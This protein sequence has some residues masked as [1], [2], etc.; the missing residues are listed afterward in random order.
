MQFQLNKMTLCQLF[1][2]SYNK[3]DLILS[4]HLVVFQQLVDAWQVL[5]DILWSESLLR[6]FEPLLDVL[7]VTVEQTLLPRLLKLGALKK[8]GGNAQNDTKYI[9]GFLCSSDHD[10]NWK[11][12]TE[13][14]A[15]N[16]RKVFMTATQSLPPKSSHNKPC[17]SCV[18]YISQ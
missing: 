11:L 17:T 18:A 12:L 2:S 16:F 14:K 3:L 1:P 5:S 7:H 4:F 9:V 6:L 15:L 8:K 13:T 10:H